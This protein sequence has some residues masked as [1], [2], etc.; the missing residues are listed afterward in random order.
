MAAGLPK[1]NGPSSRDAPLVLNLSITEVV[2]MSI[3]TARFFFLLITAF[4]V[5]PGINHAAQA[6]MAWDA[7]SP[8]PEGYRLY[9]RLVNTAYTTPVWSGTGTS[10]NVANLNDDTT[11]Y[12]V[13]RAYTGGSES[14]D[15]N[16][17]TF[18]STSI[19]T[20][21]LSATAGPNGSIT[22]AGSTTV[23][24]GASQSYTIAPNA[25]YH[26][27]DVRVDGLSVGTPTSYTFSNVSANRTIAATFALN[28]YTISATA[29]ANGS[30]SPAGN[31]TVSYGAGLAFSITPDTGYRVSEVVVDGKP[32]GAMES[33][34]FTGIVSN[35]AI[36]A[37]FITANQPP[38]A[39]AGPDQTVAEA[40]IVR[41]SGLNASDPDDGIAA[42]TWRQLS[43]PSVQLSSTTAAETTFTAPS[44]GTQGAALVFELTV[45]DYSG[46]SAS[47]TCIV[48]VTWVNRPP[49][50]QAGADQIVNEG[51]VVHLDGANSVD[52]DDGLASYSWRQVQGPA[53][54]LDNAH[55]ITPSFIA[56]DVMPQGD[57]LR[58][59]LTV[60]DHG[61]LQDTDE[62][63]VTVV[64]VN[65]PPS[66]DAGPD[67]TVREGEAVILDGANSMDPDDGIALYQWRQTEGPPVELSDASSIKPTFIAP[68]VPAEGATLLFQLAVIDHAGLQHHDTCMVNVVTMNQPPMA[69][70]GADQTVE[71]GSVV[72]LDGSASTDSDDGI[73]DY[74]WTQ[75]GGPVVTLSDAQSPRPTF[76]AP[77]V[78]PQGATL[79]FNL[80]VIDYSGL[81]SEGTCRV[82]VTWRNQ[83]P[84]ASAGPDR[85]VV[86]KTSVTLDGSASTDP[87]DG[88]A[89]HR[90][91]QVAGPP[92]ALGDA[93]AVM[94]KITAPEV[95]TLSQLV[96]EL[97]VTD[98]GGL[99]SVDRCTVTVQPA[100]QNDTTPP[101][102]AVT[103][104]GSSFAF[105][106]KSKITVKGTAGD[107][108][109][110]SRIVW[111]NQYGDSGQATG[112]TAWQF[113]LKL[114]RW[115]NEI[116]IS[117]YDA[118]GNHTAVRIDIFAGTWR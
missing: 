12:F 82:N 86:A 50:A 111:R 84:V 29:G 26:V 55:A 9:Q 25:G 62:C 37:T 116:T 75:V 90:W 16:E 102:L 57:S 87:D 21:T 39:D 23:A 47:D 22:P 7:G 54:Q 107:D 5:I 43:G 41:L 78:D 115:M 80:T 88:I 85:T 42:L 24:A 76:T 110:L 48:N 28:T 65:A 103:T 60:T 94:T 27:A 100:V 89:A 71:E 99:Q 93:S 92:A 95:D 104:P 74:Q 98:W 49:T 109:G 64:W 17:V 31:T 38:H 15:S 91:K 114:R 53:V 61:G 18:R 58:F 96:F 63:L 69:V 106:T 51:A 45:S 35:H 66:A 67:Q 56:A 83:P 1:A 97:T 73:S 34:A 59:E 79:A 112:T 68:N 11:Y 10:C 13:V 52:P 4:L 6:T 113:D 33:Y 118:A 20:Y 117:A 77:Q 108:R 2:Y 46:L 8:A 105:T 30:I 36:A 40:A 32:I 101:T 70:V 81:K 44:V 14:A 72:E 3:R 19:V